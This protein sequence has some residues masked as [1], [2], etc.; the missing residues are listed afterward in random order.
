LFGVRF[1]P[2]F[3][4]KIR[5][6]GVDLASKSGV[7][8]RAADAGVVIVAGEPP[9]YRGYGRIVIIDHGEN[10]YGQRVSSVYA[11]QSRIMVHEGQSVRQGEVIGLVGST[12]YATGPHL[13]FEIRINGVPVNPLD[14]VQI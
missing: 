4:R 6:M 13:H 7:P 5:H 9:Q 12:G 14:Y 2:I 8:I 3:K 1:H 11:H 10:K